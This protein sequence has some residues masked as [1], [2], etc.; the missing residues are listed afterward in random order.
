MK[1]IK[2]ALFDNEQEELDF[3]ADALVKMFKDRGIEVEIQRNRMSNWGSDD[4]KRFLTYRPEIAIFDNHVGEEPLQEMF[5]QEVISKIK[6]LVPDCIFALLTKVDIK[7][8]SLP[9]KLPHPDVI[10]QKHQLEVGS[11]R[12]SDWV[13]KELS[14]NISKASIEKI[15]TSKADKQISGLRAKDF[16]GKNR[17]IQRNELESLIRQVCYT[18]GGLH[19]NII[20]EVKLEPLFGGKSDAVVTV[21]S[22]RNRYGAFQVPAVLKIMRREAAY[23]EAHNHSKYVKW[24]LPYRWRVDI[25]GKGY[26]ADFGAVCYSFAH[27]GAG[28]PE[29]LDKLIGEGEYSRVKAVIEQVFDPSKQAWYSQ[30]RDGGEGEQP[31]NIFLGSC[32]PYFSPSANEIDREREVR[33]HVQTIS[34]FEGVELLGEE[35]S[36]RVKIGD[37]DFATASLVSQFLAIR[38]VAAAKIC[39]SHGDLNAANILVNEGSS[40]FC[41]IDFQHTGWH[42]RARD[43]CSLEGSIRTRIPPRSTESFSDLVVQEVDAWVRVED[44]IFLVSKDCNLLDVLRQRYFMNHKS[45]A[46]EFAMSNFVHTLW[47]LSFKFKDSNAW[48]ELQETRLLASLFGTWIAIH[49]NLVTN[50][51]FFIER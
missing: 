2:I 10:L 3:S 18:G 43:F 24:V 42:H 29:T 21:I 40:E 17:P 4:L 32:A 25:I 27:G 39:L 22:V 49:G 20:D 23:R 19:E 37:Y 36:G 11:K 5:G 34:R 33:K 14:G 12:Y 41:F 51:E 50:K 31:L 28:L 48:S 45:S 8:N 1:P 15:D 38:E 7:S 44:E 9:N 30:D 47:L 6:P 13:V 26:T 16:R 46:M 35:S